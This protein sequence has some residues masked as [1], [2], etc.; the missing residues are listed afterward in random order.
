MMNEWDQTVRQLRH[1]V[2]YVMENPRSLANMNSL[3][4]ISSKLLFF[5][6]D[7]SP[8]DQIWTVRVDLTG[9]FEEVY[10]CLHRAQ[11]YKNTLQIIISTA[12]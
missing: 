7:S 11:H 1:L 4:L 12:M 2:P 3:N 8:H 5:R 10:G 6:E 9:L